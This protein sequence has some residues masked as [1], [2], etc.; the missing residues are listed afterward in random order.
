MQSSRD[1]GLAGW[2]DGIMKDMSVETVKL[3]MV[4]NMG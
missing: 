3:A 1:G 4:P 2:I